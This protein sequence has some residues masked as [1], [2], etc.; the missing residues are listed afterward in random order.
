MYSG[1]LGIGYGHLIPVFS[2]L[3]FTLAGL[4][5]AGLNYN[6]TKLFERTDGQWAGVH[7]ISARAG[8][9]Y[10]YGN[11][12]SGLQMIVD[13]NTANVRD[14]EIQQA[15]FSIRL[16]YAYRF[17]GVDMPFLDRMSDWMP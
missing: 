9:G 10:N 15:T 8:A 13:S 2:R 1:V 5:A 3:Y 7:R 14:G 17:Q 6:E 4:L 11:H 16:F 12:V